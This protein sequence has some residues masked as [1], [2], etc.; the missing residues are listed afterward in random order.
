[1]KISAFTH[2]Q[3][4]DHDQ[5]DEALGDLATRLTEATGQ[6]WSVQHEMGGSSVFNAIE[7][8]GCGDFDVVSVAYPHHITGEAV[9]ID[10][11]QIVHLPPD[12]YLDTYELYRRDEPL[13]KLVD[14]FKAVR[15]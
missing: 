10:L 15:S 11:W 2:E 3:M 6:K 13:Q 12:G 7:V 4:D 1:M 5:W 8:S 14:F 9:D